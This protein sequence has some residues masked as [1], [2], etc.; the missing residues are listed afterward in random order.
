VFLLSRRLPPAVDSSLARSAAVCGLAFP[1]IAP[2][3]FAWPAGRRRSRRIAWRTPGHRRSWSGWK[4]ALPVA[5]GMT[6]QRSSVL[7]FDRSVDC[8]L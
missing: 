7:G 4:L 6:R 3:M 5:R 1:V 8:G 2:R